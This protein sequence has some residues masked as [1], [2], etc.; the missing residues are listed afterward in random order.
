[1]DRKLNA[2][3]L[4]K[5]AVTLTAGNP[6][7][8]V[9]GRFAAVSVQADYVEFE[10]TE[11]PEVA[12]SW[13]CGPCTVVFREGDRHQVLAG[14]LTP[15][16]APSGGPTR[17]R[18]GLPLNT[19]PVELRSAWRIPIEPGSG[20]TLR[21]HSG[22]QV[23]VPRAL[24]ISPGGILADFGDAVDNGPGDGEGKLE[25]VLEELRAELEVLPQRRSGNAFILYFSQVLRS[26]RHGRLA[27]PP[28]LRPIFDRLESRW[29][30]AH[31]AG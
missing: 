7:R 27:T 31:S 11:P 5:R 24:D 6:P 15:G 28:A 30:T 17:V 26:L 19:A 9:A 1:M 18:V 20:L 29:L 22:G 2:L 14:N 13:G 12:V 16:P 25:V 4:E 10:L 3:C 8:I 23:L 21:L